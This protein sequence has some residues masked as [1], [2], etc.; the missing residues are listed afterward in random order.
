MAS[1]ADLHEC[2]GSTSLTRFANLFGRRGGGHG[3]QYSSITEIEEVFA[4]LRHATEA[5]NVRGQYYSGGLQK[6]EP[7]K[8]ASIRVPEL[9]PFLTRNNLNMPFSFDVKSKPTLVGQPMRVIVQ[10]DWTA[11]C[12]VLYILPFIFSNVFEIK[13]SVS[14]LL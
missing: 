9:Q 1:M 11:S 10:L 3:F 2:P 6:L 7:T 13:R 14:F 5:F 4:A 8:L 12:T